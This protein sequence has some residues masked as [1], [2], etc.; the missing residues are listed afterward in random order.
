MTTLRVVPSSIV[1]EVTGLQFPAE[2]LAL[3]CRIN[4]V[5]GE[6]HERTIVWV[7][8]SRMLN[9]GAQGACTAAMNP[10]YPPSIT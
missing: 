8:V 9:L 10:Q 5:D 3:D 6:G 2:R 1:G 4:C 7:A